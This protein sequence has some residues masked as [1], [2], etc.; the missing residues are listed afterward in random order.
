MTDGR[1]TSLPRPV[2][3]GRYLLQSELGRGGMACVY[4]ADDTT[5]GVERAIKILAEEGR[6]KAGRRRRLVNEARAMARLRHPSVVMVHEAGLCE[7]GPYVVMDLLAGGTLADRLRER[8]PLPATEAIDLLLPVLDALHAGHQQGI[9]HRDVKPSNVLLDASDRPAL[10]DYGIALLADDDERYTRTG[11]AVGSVAFMAP[12][13]RLDARSVTAAADVYAAGTTLY[14]LV[15]GGTPVDLFTADVSSPR[16]MDVPEDLRPVLRRATQLQ[17]EDRYPTAAAFAD[18]LAHARDRMLGLRSDPL[19]DDRTIDEPPDLTTMAGARGA[20]PALRGPLEPA[21][22][23]LDTGWVVAAL[24][25][26]AVV[27]VGGVTVPWAVEPAPGDAPAEVGVVD[28]EVEAAGGGDEAVADAEEVQAPAAGE[29]PPPS[30]PEGAAEDAPAA[31]PQE[32]PSSTRPA[33]P[34]EAPPDDDGVAAITPV[35]P[36]RPALRPGAVDVE[37]LLAHAPGDW[38]ALPPRPGPSGAPWRGVWVF[39]DGPSHHV[40][41][42]RGPPGALRARGW[43]VSDAGKVAEPLAFT[44]EVSEGTA[45]LRR[46]W[47]GRT[48]VYGL[49]VQGAEPGRAQVVFTQ[50]NGDLRLLGTA[51][52]VGD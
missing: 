5:L 38:Y 49:R 16:W 3:G 9:V 44:G 2:V 26:G 42:V 30:P 48:I 22:R 6:G 17:P 28:G 8:G 19:P 33:P 18:A 11:A 25:V 1:T 40:F 34:P 36:A 45:Y 31:A 12:E 52:R 14:R 4:R 29:A 37:A 41:D 13:Q 15:T 46:P 27:V 24:L 21:P 20:E 47:R 51:D 39:A 50:S 32:A 35:P 23:G 43:T 10:A 7:E